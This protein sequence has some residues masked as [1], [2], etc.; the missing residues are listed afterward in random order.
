[1]LTINSTIY[2]LKS[3]LFRT[4]FITQRFRNAWDMR[5][6]LPTIASFGS[7]RCPA[8]CSKICALINHRLIECLSSCF[9]VNIENEIQARDFEQESKLMF[10][11]RNPCMHIVYISETILLQTIFRLQMCL[12]LLHFGCT[13]ICLIFRSMRAVI[14]D[15]QTRRG[16]IKYIDNQSFSQLMGS[17]K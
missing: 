2:S 5:T 7:T 3:M 11:H 14:G 13:G 17:F 15:L 9:C 8:V 12:S 6:G 1:M 4:N 10:S 16:A